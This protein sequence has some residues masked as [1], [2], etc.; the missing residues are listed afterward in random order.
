[1]KRYK[2]KCFPF[3]KNADFSLVVQEK[4]ILFLFQRQP[5]AG[6]ERPK[7]RKEEEAL[8]SATLPS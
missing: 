4:V 7:G 8:V 1:M 2:R 3:A 5:K 6:R